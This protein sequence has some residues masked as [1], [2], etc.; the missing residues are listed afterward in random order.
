MANLRYP[1]PKMNSYLVNVDNPIPKDDSA[2][3][4]LPI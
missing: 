3:E 2:D 4:F 1:A